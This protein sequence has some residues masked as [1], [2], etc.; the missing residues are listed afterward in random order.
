VRWIVRLAPFKFRVRHSK[1]VENVVADALS[2][3]FEGQK[4]EDPEKMCGSLIAALPL[5][6]SSLKEH[7]ASDDFCQ[8]LSAQ[9][10]GKDRR[11]ENFQLYEGNL[12]YFPK[13]GKKRRFVLP[14]SLTTMALQYFHDGI[15]GGHL[16]ARKT[17]G[18]VSANFWWLGMARDVFAYV[19]KCEA[20][21]KVAGRFN[22]NRRPHGFKVGDHVRYRLNVLSSKAQ[23]VSA[24]MA[25]RWS[26][27]MVIL[28]DVCPNVVLLAHPVTGV[29]DRRAQVSQLKR[30]GE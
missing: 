11:A 19:R 21:T 20:N 6:Y 25:L 30:C 3:M 22:K 1:G 4:P 8:R 5:L 15:L 18:K 27:P 12:C 2:R 16:G 23:G 17:L 29:V 10:K 13:R 26:E 24:K 9:I 28:R 14:S 7:Q